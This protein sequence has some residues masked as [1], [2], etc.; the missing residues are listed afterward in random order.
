M[1]LDDAI[2]RL[3]AGVLSESLDWS[4]VECNEDPGEPDLRTDVRLV[5]F[6][7]EDLQKRVETLRDKLFNATCA[8]FSWD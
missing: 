8:R 2:R 6:E 1:K 3:E 4:Y 7:I 5:L